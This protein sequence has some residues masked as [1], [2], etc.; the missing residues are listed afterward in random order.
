MKLKLAL[1]FVTAICGFFV[2][3]VYAFF[4]EDTVSTNKHTLSE[5]VLAAT[6]PLNYPSFTFIVGRERKEHTYTGMVGNRLSMSANVGE[7]VMM[8][9]DFVGKSESG[10]AAFWTNCFSFQTH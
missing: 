8:S 6:T 1:F 7:Y 10:T 9:A 2:Q 3:P 5:P 4:P